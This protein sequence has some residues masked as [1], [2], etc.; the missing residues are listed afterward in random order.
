MIVSARELERK[1]RRVAA[2]SRGF[3]PESGWM[4]DTE[5]AERIVS[6]FPHVNVRDGFRL[7]TVVTRQS[8]GG[9]GWTFALPEEVAPPS[10]V[11]VAAEDR[12]PPS[13][14]SGALPDL[15]EG[16]EGDG[17]L[18]AFA[19]AAILGRELAELGA[20]WHGI[21]WV[22]HTLLAGRD[23]PGTLSDRWTWKG[24]R[25]ERWD[26][27]VERDGSSVTVTFWTSSALGGERI[28]RHTDRFEA[29]SLSPVDITEETIA[30]A[31]G[32]FIP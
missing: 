29:G 9:N 17:T 1:R 31:A 11:R 28:V 26:P 5:T 14:P 18:W 8:S 15:M 2:I 12:F 21:D 22:M 23:D 4:V 25:P 13:R 6:V 32:G 30:T 20:W 7:A 27:T 3:G 16:L 19:E 24:D 10:P